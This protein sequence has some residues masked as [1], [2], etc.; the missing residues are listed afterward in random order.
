MLAEEVWGLVP[1]YGAGS[2]LQGMAGAGWREALDVDQILG[3]GRLLRG[4]R[5]I[6]ETV[7]Y[8]QTAHGWGTGA[9]P[10]REEPSST[11][12]CLGET[13]VAPGAPRGKP[14]DKDVKS[15]ARPPCFSSSCFP[16]AGLTL[17]P[18]LASG[19]GWKCVYASK[20]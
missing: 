14:S 2:G 3:I 6:C 20:H 12:L 8:R 19:P 16:G 9:A 7:V 4:V 17:A 1:Q 5:S 10:D 15:W 11:Q 18:P 13:V